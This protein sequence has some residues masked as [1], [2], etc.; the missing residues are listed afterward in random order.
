MNGGGGNTMGEL[1]GLLKSPPDLTYRQCLVEVNEFTRAAE[2]G[3]DTG[4]K[5]RALSGPDRFTSACRVP[6]WGNGRAKGILRIVGRVAM[7]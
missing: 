3:S 5:V 1:T 6:N 2:G 7:L 4:I